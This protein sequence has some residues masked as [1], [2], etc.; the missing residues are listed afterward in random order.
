[1]L[2]RILMHCNK[3]PGSNAKTKVHTTSKGAENSL[4]DLVVEQDYGFNRGAYHSKK[5]RTLSEKSQ[6]KILSKNP[7][8]L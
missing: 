2:R 4:E 5:S 7:K 3:S 6:T 8:I 1:M